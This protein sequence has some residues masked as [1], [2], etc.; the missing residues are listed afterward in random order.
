MIMCMSE[1]TYLFYIIYHYKK[2]QNEEETKI[3]SEMKTAM[4]QIGAYIALNIILD[5]VVVL[6]VF[7]TPLDYGIGNQKMSVAILA[8]TYMGGIQN[9]M[10]SLGNFFF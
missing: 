2:N 3:D 5:Y 1:K 6:V 4:R 9:K 10:L 7:S 8:R